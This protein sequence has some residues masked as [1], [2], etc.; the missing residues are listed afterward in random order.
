M[1]YST[2]FKIGK[3]RTGT[4][5]TPKP[6]SVPNTTAIKIDNIFKKR[7][8]LANLTDAERLACDTFSMFY[9]SVNNAISV[10]EESLPLT[11]YANCLRTLRSKLEED[12]SP[13]QLISVLWNKMAIAIAIKS[14]SS[15]CTKLSHYKYSPNYE[16]EKILIFAGL[17]VVIS[18][19]FPNKEK[20]ADIVNA[21]RATAHS[22]ENKEYFKP[23][24]LVINAFNPDEVYLELT[25]AISSIKAA[26]KPYK[27]LALY[28]FLCSQFSNDEATIN[29]IKQECASVPMSEPEIGAHIENVT[30]TDG[31]AMNMF[32]NSTV[33]NELKTL[34]STDPQKLISDEHQ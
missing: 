2:L 15:E 3:S 4:S 21:I 8:D 6:K 34:P 31:G 22:K 25:D 29:Y 17:M 14:Y 18:Q 11:T 9:S 33:H 16:H 1:A 28:E 7:N 30:V 12:T 23:F 24:D 32:D 27:A 19:S 13:A 10:K 5:K 20:I 26:T